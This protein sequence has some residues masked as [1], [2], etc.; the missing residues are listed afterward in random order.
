M[1]TF[2]VFR[3]NKKM[4]LAVLGVL[5]MLSFVFIPTLEQCN[6]NFLPGKQTV[7]VSKMFGNLTGN[8]FDLIRMQQSAV[9]E[10]LMQGAFQGLDAQSVM[11]TWLK[12][13]FAEKMGFVVG[14]S[15]IRE[16][17]LDTY[18]IVE[19][20]FEEGLKELI[21]ASKYTNFCLAGIGQQMNMQGMPFAMPAFPPTIEQQWNYFCALNRS[22]TLEVAAVKAEDYLTKVA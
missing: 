4:S 12:A 18:R 17:A 1:S 21:L 9:Y 19:L 11:S 22:A 7:F 10:V 14:D 6:R 5:T 2:S 15:E 13:R 20:T 8:E 16:M 3:R